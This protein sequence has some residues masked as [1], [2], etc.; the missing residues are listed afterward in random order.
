[1]QEIKKLLNDAKLRID[2]ADHL[3]FVT[4]PQVRE[5]KML[6]GITEHLNNAV[7]S[8]I[9]AVVKY[10]MM[11]KRLPF[12]KNKELELFKN[13]CA[14]KYG[15]N[16]NDLRVIDEII[17]IVKF[18]KNAPVEFVRKDKFVICTEN[19]KMKVINLHMVKDYLQMI[20]RFSNNVSRV[21]K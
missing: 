12:I 18:R 6:Y 16:Y 3:T 13:K 14:T 9:S 8:L 11:Y 20:K 1:M 2:T 21:I 17:N 15:L 7:N 19:Y 10:E 4:Y 5:V